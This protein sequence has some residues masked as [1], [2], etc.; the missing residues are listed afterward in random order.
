M[1]SLFAFLFFMTMLSSQAQPI[2]VMTYNIRY[3]TPQ[4]SVNQWP[5]RAHK[6]YALDQEIRSR[7]HW[8][9]RS[10]ASTA[11]GPGPKSSCVY[12]YR[13]R[14]RRWENKRRIFSHIFIRK[15]DSMRSTKIHF[16]CPKL[17]RYQAAKVGMQRSH[18]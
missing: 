18:E 5:K 2:K 6:V 11:D 15:I 4:D 9:S 10:A 14:T 13:C 16:G 17:L 12:L 7:S 3:D 1:R 8:T